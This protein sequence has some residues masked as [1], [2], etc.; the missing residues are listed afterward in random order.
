MNVWEQRMKTVL[1]WRPSCRGTSTSRPIIMWQMLVYYSSNDLRNGVC[2]LS[3]TAVDGWHFTL[4]C[5]NVVTWSPADCNQSLSISV[6]RSSA[7]DRDQEQNHKVVDCQLA[8]HS[9]SISPLFQPLLS[10]CQNYTRFQGCKN[11][12]EK[13]S[14]SPENVLQFCS[15]QTHKAEV[16]ECVTWAWRV[17]RNTTA[18]DLQVYWAIWATT[19]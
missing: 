1:H 14:I 6:E 19:S 12:L 4:Y 2:N 8:H 3:T 10:A 13:A 9:L 11:V 15:A 18:Y 5:T 16:K 17:P 7:Q